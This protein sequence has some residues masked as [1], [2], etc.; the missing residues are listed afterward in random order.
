MPVYE[1]P[2]LSLSYSL[3][4]PRDAAYVLPDVSGLFHLAPTPDRPHRLATQTM[5]K[6]PPS[7]HPNRSPTSLV[8]NELALTAEQKGNIRGVAITLSDSESEVAS[9]SGSEES[10]DEDDV[11]ESVDNEGVQGYQ[12]TS[13]EATSMPNTK[14]STQNGARVFGAQIRDTPPVKSSP[15]NATSESSDDQTSASET[16]DEEQEAPDDSESDSADLQ[17]EMRDA[18]QQSIAQ[19]EESSDDEDEEESGSQD[20]EV[21]LEG[22][23]EQTARMRM[24]TTM[25]K[26]KNRKSSS[27]SFQ[28][29]RRPNNPTTLRSLKYQR[30]NAAA[31]EILIKDTASAFAASSRFMAMGTHNGMVHILTYEGSKVKSFRPHA[32][33]VLDIKICDADEFVATASVE[34]ES[35]VASG[36]DEHACRAASG[37]MIADHVF[38]LS[39]SLSDFPC[40]AGRVMING[41]TSPEK[42]A[43]DLKRPVKAV[44]LEP[45][46]SKKTSRA[47]VCG[48]M[49]GAVVMHEKGWLGHKEQVLHSG[50]GPIYAIQWRGNL[51]AW[52]NDLGVK[53]YDTN[54]Q[55]RITYI[56]RPANSP[57][58][59]LFKCNLFWQDDHTL[60]IAWADHIKV[61][62][63]REHSSRITATALTASI[64][65]SVEITAIFQ[66]DCMISGICPY[67]KNQ[68][69]GYLILAY[70]LSDHY[71][72]EATD[73]PAEQR[74]KAANRPELR[75]ISA[76]GEEIS[77]DALSLNNYHLYGCNDYV[78]A[79]SRRA[80]EELYVV[81]S[82]KDVILARPRDA[83]DHVHWLVERKQFAEALHMA[84][85]LADKHGQG[86]D[87][88]AIGIKYI[89]HLFEQELYDA[90]A[91]LC[92]KVLGKDVK[93]WEDWIFA[94]MQRQ[95][96]QALLRTIKKW[97]PDI[98]DVQAVVVAVQGEL[99][100]AKSSSTLMECLA[101]LHVIQHQPS[102][103]LPYLLRL[104]RPEVFDFVKEHNLFASVQDQVLLLIDF[105]KE[106]EPLTNGT[107]KEPKDVTQG[108]TSNDEPAATT[109]HGKAIAL[110]IDHTYSIPIPRVVNQL[111]S[112][113]KYLYMYLDALF[114]KDPHL[115][116]EY[117]DR[118]VELYAEYEYP[119]L[120]EYLRASNYY[121]LE[122]AYRICKE[123]DFVPEM[124][125]LLGRMGNNKQALMLIIQRLGD[126][127][128]AIEFAREQADEDLWEDLLRY[129]EDKPIFIRGLLENVGSDINP[130]RLIRRIKDGLEIPGLKPA[131]IKI[132]QA[133][134]LQV[135]LLEG[136]GK[137]LNGDAMTLARKLHRA[138]TSG[139]YAAGDSRC[140][141]CNDH[142]FK[143]TS[144]LTPLAIIY[145]CHHLV[146]ADCALMD[147]VSDSLPLRPDPVNSMLFASQMN[148]QS[149]GGVGA[150]R[151]IDVLGKNLGGKL[152]YAA[153]LRVKLGKCPVCDASRGTTGAVKA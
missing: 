144:S 59:D 79:P 25:K 146:H 71:D 118:L 57:R 60:L 43:A 108:P 10:G 30:L 65:Y 137:I 66:V 96:L 83:A 37:G 11:G 5:A 46:F 93:A 72:N 105:D 23:E 141:V 12:V 49:G 103:A 67:E 62:R 32:A 148:S 112:R 136:A 36:T 29:Q 97:P 40:G 7:T 122:K 51:I 14:T 9:G 75:I 28:S 47:F 111:A 52:A 89:H 131:I 145:L 41:I 91:A 69:G 86:L 3:A 135:S 39:L 94:F 116:V 64:T 48:G 124:V 121:S 140:Q 114:R 55:Q 150:P 128:R 74:R 56:D 6:P 76:R 15:D 73:D 19:R 92:P 153:T 106:S 113:P 107:N 125:F 117:S 149:G 127:Q 13:G 123:R 27:Y 143:P 101:E 110:L 138:Q 85:M 50:E 17:Q 90:A 98:Y 133:S 68:E 18:I 45:G 109:R 126:V 120:M 24:R 134:N 139:V 152:A 4:V 77:S 78:L 44:A 31:S 33:S 84:E 22:I 95:Q 151:R 54:T 34:G 8:E 119:C 82:P 61:A 20:E 88:R 70:V 130:L 53:I 102:K 2:P 142:V 35:P 99:E 63:I 38:S 1:L 26:K 80:S 42:Y 100:A 147:T 58:A 129:S 115:T 21:V 132:L 81:V 104:R 87:V 16:D